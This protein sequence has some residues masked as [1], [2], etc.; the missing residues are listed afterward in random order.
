MDKAM[1]IA[2]EADGE[3]L[4]Q[5]TGKDHGPVFIAADPFCNVC[6]A[7]LDWEHDHK[8]D[9][10]GLDDGPYLPGRAPRKAMEPKSSEETRATREQAWAT[11]RE[12]Y[13]PNGHR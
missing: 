5:L 8:P 10:S 13:G 6:G 3:K 7:P 2:L 1:Q 4:R 9:N 11:R 12:K